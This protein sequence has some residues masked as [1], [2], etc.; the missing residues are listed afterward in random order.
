MFKLTIKT[1]NDAFADNAHVKMEPTVST[2]TLTASNGQPIRKAT[3][4]TFSDGHVVKFMERMPARS[5]LRQA[6]EVREREG[7]ADG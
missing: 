5:A 7:R 3:A 6:V 1:A 4:V 2:Y